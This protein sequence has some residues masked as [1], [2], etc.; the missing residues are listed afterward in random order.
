MSLSFHS[1]P[2]THKKP[3]LVVK[4][5]PETK[6]SYLYMGSLAYQ[7]P[8]KVSVFASRGKRGHFSFNPQ[9]FFVYFRGLIFT[10]VSFVPCHSRLAI[11]CVTELLCCFLRSPS[12]S[13]PYTVNKII[14]SGPSLFCS[15]LS[16]RFA[17]KEKRRE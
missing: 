4:A 9:L 2:D 11:L 12:T 8:L 16:T 14:H 10:I 1:L 3:R 17:P 6:S 13:C 15:C 5:S 7:R